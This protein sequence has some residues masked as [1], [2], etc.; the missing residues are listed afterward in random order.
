[1]Y[2]FLHHCQFGQPTGIKLPLEAKGLIRKPKSWGIRTTAT[3]P[4]GHGMAATPLQMISAFSALLNDGQYQQPRIVD[5]TI[6]RGLE[7]VTNTL[8]SLPPK[9]LFSSRTSKAVIELLGYGTGPGS[10]G[11]QARYGEYV[12]IGKTG[13]SQLVNFAKGGYLT[14]S[15][16]AVF[17]G[18]YPQTNPQFSALVI[19]NNPKLSYYGGK[20]AA[21]LFSRLLPDLFTAYGLKQQHPNWINNTSLKRRPYNTD[22]RNHQMPNLRGQSLRDV[23]IALHKMRTVFQ[24]KDL[25][26]EVR[27]EGRGHVV[28]QDPRPWTDVKDKSTIVIYL[29]PK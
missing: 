28:K 3:I 17:I 20:V 19:V 12:P 6:S 8:P 15:Y 18:A 10:T 21:P 26:F 27:I 4:M 22:F 23:L 11:K 2:D 14:N 13:T 1:M 24:A 25:S 9:R 16:N 5:K 29:Q 7:I